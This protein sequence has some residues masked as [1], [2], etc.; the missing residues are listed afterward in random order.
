MRHPFSRREFHVSRDSRQK[1]GFHD[2]LFSLSGNVIFADYHAARVFTH[3]LNLKRDLITYPE[4]ALRASDLYAMGLIDEILHYIIQLYCEQVKSTVMNEALE[5]ISKNFTAGAQQLLHRFISEFPP[6]AVHLGRVAVPEYFSESGNSEI[7][8]EEMIL[9]WLANRNP[10]FDPFSELFDE[11]IL[12]RSAPY[13]QVF[14]KIQNFF[15]SQPAFGPD[16]QTLIEML[17]AP[18]LASPYSLTGQ[19]DFIRSRWGYLIADRYLYKLLS[20]LDY[21]REEHTARGMGPG[22]AVVPDYISGLSGEPERFSPDKDWMPNV[23]LVAKNAY[24]WLDQLSRE[25]GQTLNRLD[26]IPDKTLDQISG[27]GFTA[28]WLIGIWERSHASKRIKKMCGNP[29][30]EASAYALYD[31]QIAGDL[32][33]EAAFQN[34]KNRAWQRGIRLSGDM[35]PNHVGI[36]GKWVINHPDWFISLPYSPY[37]SYTFH[38]PDLSHEERVGIYLEDHYYTRNDAA[39]VFK[40]RDH[41]TGDERYIYHGNDGTSMPWNDTAQLNYL[42]SEVREAVI[43]T[44]L[45]VAR[46]FPII[47]FDAAMTLTQKH[48]QRLWFPEP[49]HGGDIASRSEHGMTRKHFLEAMPHEFWR[50]V[51]DRVADEAPD[52]LLLAEAFWLLEGYFVRSL[53]MH[54]VYNS[55]FMNMLKTENNAGYRD[56]IRKTLAFNPEI[57]KRFVNFMN[58]PDEDTAVA[59]FGRDDKYFGCCLLMVTLPG[60]PMFGHGQ[61]E[62]FTEKYGME[63]RRAYWDENPDEGLVRRHERQVFPVLRKRYLFAEVT[64]YCLYDV[65]T[66][67][68]HINEDIFAHSNRSGNECALYVYHNRWAESRGWIRRSI[69]DGRSLGEGLGLKRDERLFTIFRDHISGLEY[70]RRNHEFFESGLFVELGAF[71]YHLFWEFRQVYDEHGSYHR[72][73]EMLNGRGVP[74]IEDAVKE[75]GLRPVLDPFYEW[76]ESGLE[77]LTGEE[78]ARKETEFSDSF[79]RLTLSFFNALKARVNGSAEAE[80]FA[81]QTLSRFYSL[82][83][84]RTGAKSSREY[85][86]QDASLSEKLGVLGWLVTADLGRL[87]NSPNSAM[88]SRSWIDELMLGK[89]IQQV[90]TAKGLGETGQWEAVSILKLLVA[91]PMD[92]TRPDA[93]PVQIFNSL[94]SDYDAQSY[95]QINRYQDVLYFNRE[96]FQSLIKTWLLMNQVVIHNLPPGNRAKARGLFNRMRTAIT[97]AEDKSKYRLENFLKELERI[98]LAHRTG[99]NQHPPK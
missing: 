86:I 54:R 50:E 31:Y 41:W 84:P 35:V 76:L 16:N 89:I 98:W 24:V 11:A 26:Q 9:L 52:T 56:V 94:F 78:T 90:G 99:R 63:Y 83:K 77:I 15:K 13:R 72:L 58:N 44:I 85:V 34:L 91:H 28:L 42:N 67:E 55:A 87:V 23:V 79:S 75:M 60:L 5:F 64:A 95:L 20:S 14:E 33:G 51:V 40:R 6:L 70:I 48:F 66:P 43:Q 12:E 88:I 81:E 82:L 21:I 38:G 61:I 8:L 25:S 37:P 62:G 65:V 57:L 17:R 39:V 45:H 32:G 59:Q 36:D 2:L 27:W 97:R 18:A 96:R 68:G 73:S 3:Q 19:L 69:L 74:S 46:Q 4:Q 49:G 22:L 53:G 7:A 80:I 29:E 1:Y 30:A 92:F 47:R 10:A 93:S 71:K